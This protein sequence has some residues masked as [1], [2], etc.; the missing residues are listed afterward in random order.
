[1]DDNFPYAMKNISKWEWANKPDGAPHNDPNDKGGFTKYGIAQNYHK[2]IDVASLDLPGAYQVYKEGYWNPFNLGLVS[3]KDVASAL[4]DTTVQHGVDRDT[5]HMIQ[6]AVIASGVSI[7]NDGVI[8]PKTIAAINS[9]PAKPFIGKLYDI[10]KNYYQ[11]LAAHDAKSASELKGWLA[12]ISQYKYVAV[13]GGLATLGLIA[14][15]V[16]F[17][18]RWRKRKNSK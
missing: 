13:G 11:T 14:V 8:G 7:A 15:G 18:L 16:F 1:M 4:L 5:A 10:R 17:Y 9:L 12:R 3:D 6:Q 2:D